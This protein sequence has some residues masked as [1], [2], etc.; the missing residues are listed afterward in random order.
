MVYNFRYPETPP[1]EGD[2]PMRIAFFVLGLL[3]LGGPAFAA[4]PPSV[5]RHNDRPA[6]ASYSG[7]S[8]QGSAHARPSRGG[9]R[10]SP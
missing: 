1:V 9:R 4:M 8:G 7:S 6:H 5:A 10:S 2:T 3:F